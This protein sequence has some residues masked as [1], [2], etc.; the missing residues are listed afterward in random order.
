M[1]NAFS[2]V[3]AAQLSS[4]FGASF[5]ST[6]SSSRSVPLVAPQQKLSSLLDAMDLA[7]NHVS[8]KEPMSASPCSLSASL[9]TA[10]DLAS[11]HAPI[12]GVQKSFSSD[13]ASPS[14]SYS[15]APTSQ[16][17]LAWQKQPSLLDALS[18]E[19]DPF[20]PSG[21]RPS[22]S[23]VRV[24]QSASIT[25]ALDLA[26]T[27]PN[28]KQPSPVTAS[29]PGPDQRSITPSVSTQASY[30]SAADS[31]GSWHPIAVVW[32]HSSQSRAR[33]PGLD[34]ATSSGL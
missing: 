1:I 2:P 4:S 19:T 14:E 9:P 29:V 3:V 27:A 5:S 30:V 33:S 21:Q 22:R 18:L 17:D 15:T 26:A 11:V 24:P 10:L 8:A 25:A 31:I 7:M 34:S 13:V 32:D 6:S 28:K 12:I 23:A 20:N 16:S